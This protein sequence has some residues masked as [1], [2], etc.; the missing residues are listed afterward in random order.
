MA[1]RSIWKGAISFGLVNI[2]IQ[3][4]SAEQKEEYTSFSQLCQKGHKIKYKKWCPVEEREVPWSEIKKG[5]EITKNNYVVIEKEEIENIKLKTTNS[6]E[7][8]EFINSEEFDPLFVERSYYV[9]PDTGKKKKGSNNATNTIPAKAYSLFVKILNETKKV[10]IG[11]V[12]LRD[13]EQLVAL[14]AYQRGLVMHQLKYL[15]E[16]RPMDEIGGLDSAQKID[17]NELSLGKTLVE[18]LTAEEFDLGQYS[19][20]YAK[21][22]EKLIEAK[23][24]GEKVTINEEEEKPEE[25][26]DLLEAL[27]AS[28]NT[29]TKPS[30]QKRSN[31]GRKE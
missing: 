23:S 31:G 24:R 18:N 14:R 2:P 3:V 28:I 26:T 7:I 5:Y 30:R 20:A 22:L 1:A 15:D 12:V 8:K 9:G 27:R 11:K 21:E 17:A 29:Q 19:D 13:K 16:I 10:A 6:I 4:F 25:P